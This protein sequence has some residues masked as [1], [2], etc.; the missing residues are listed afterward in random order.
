MGQNFA[1]LQN[2]AHS[3]NH[4]PYPGHEPTMPGFDPS[5]RMH[6]QPNV[7]IT[8]AGDDHACGRRSAFRRAITL[9]LMQGQIGDV[10]CSGIRLRVVLTRVI[11]GAAHFLA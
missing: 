6:Q 1:S 8:A 7:V 4:H 2:D 9:H 11:G 5:N 3:A 10:S